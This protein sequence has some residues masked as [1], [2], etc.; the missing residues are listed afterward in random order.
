M[1][2]ILRHAKEHH[3]EWIIPAGSCAECGDS[4][5]VAD[6]GT[7]A[8]DYDALNVLIPGLEVAHCDDGAQVL[9]H[10][11]DAGVAVE[12]VELDGEA[13]IYQRWWDQPRGDDELGRFPLGALD[14]IAAC[15]R[16][17]EQEYRS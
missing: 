2:A 13:V 1:A 5:T 3:P 15:V 7:T 4:V 10:L 6:L 16:Q 14:D 8:L 9:C 11:I 12:V 17:A